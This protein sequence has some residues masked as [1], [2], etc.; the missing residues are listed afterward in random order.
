MSK[1]QVITLI[2]GII[3]LFFMIICPPTP[4]YF[5]ATIIPCPVYE[6]DNSNRS[7]GFSFKKI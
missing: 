4:G 1:R 2:L 7:V 3:I 6:M 5:F